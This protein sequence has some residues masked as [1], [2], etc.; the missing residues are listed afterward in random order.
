MNKRNSAPTM[1]YIYDSQTWEVLT[2]PVSD[3]RSD[4]RYQARVTP[5]RKDEIEKE[6]KERE[7]NVA[8]LVKGYQSGQV[9]PRMH[10]ARVMMDGKPVLF[11]V[12][13]HHRFEALNLAK[14]KSIEI[15]V[16]DADELTAT[17]LAAAANARNG[18]SLNTRDKQNAMRM[19]HEDENF[20]KLS[21]RDAEAVLG[22][23]THQTIAN[24]RERVKNPAQ[25]TTVNVHV[26]GSR[27][28]AI[29]FVSLGEIVFEDLSEEHKATVETAKENPDSLTL[30]QMKSFVLAYGTDAFASFA[31]PDEA[32]EVEGKVMFEYWKT[33]KKAEVTPTPAAA[34]NGKPAKGKGKGKK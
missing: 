13:G 28:R 23:V 12:D 33:E 6:K 7:E 32:L 18:R 2:V 14:V 31:H 16:T 29:T 26:L 27:A 17:R 5:T 9:I 3:I 10:I 22:C 15:N 8:R 11:V 34:K 25:K 21:L 24:Y 4:I 20:W 1:Q 30:G 19:A